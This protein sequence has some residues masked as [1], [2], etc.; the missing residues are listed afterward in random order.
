M[1]MASST[2]LAP[3]ASQPVPNTSGLEQ[4]VQCSPFGDV[5]TAEGFPRYALQSNMGNL[6]MAVTT[7]L[8]TSIS[9]LPT[10]TADC[11]LYNGDT[12]KSYVLS[13]M[14]FYIGA[15]DTTQADQHMLVF[16][17]QTA[18]NITATGVPTD[19]TNTK[20]KMNTGVYSGS[21]RISLGATVVNNGWFPIG[22]CPP[23]AAVVAGS[24]WICQETSV[25][26]RIVLPPGAAIGVTQLSVSTTA[27]AVSY[28]FEW[29][30]LVL[31]TAA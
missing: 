13:R 5:L 8:R 29:E 16:C 10:T 28:F 31:P 30:E 15:I 11:Q 3:R 14:G 20:R 7:T 27:T 12:A 6:V 17:L 25:E 19:A 1:G 18:A 23:V 21:A 24:L 2:L 4:Q 26:G 22:T 9:A